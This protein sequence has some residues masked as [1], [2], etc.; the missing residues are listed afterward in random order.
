VFAFSARRRAALRWL[1]V[2]P[3]LPLWSRAGAQEQRSDL[4]EDVDYVVIPRQ[5]LSNTERIEVAY[6]FYYG[7]QWCFQ[8][9]PL[10]ADWL[11]R[12]PVD[13]SFKRIPAL[14][15]TR[16]ATLT[17]A[18]YAFDALGLLPKLH[19]KAFNAYHHDEVNLQSE[20]ELFDWVAQQGVD[21][22][23]FEEV[24][25]SEVITTR[26]NESRALTDAFHIESTPSVAVDGRYVTNSGLTGGT[27]ALMA[28]VEELIVMV[29]A[30]RRAPQ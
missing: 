11:K 21:R 4:M 19:A 12:K 29:R 5:R 22:R 23:R 7:C 13:V 24:F 28:V 1:S 27:V 18:F 3:L 9:E 10:I 14:R 16:W 8:L 25:R 15:N 30:A 17:R 6:F 26:M 20:S 2:S